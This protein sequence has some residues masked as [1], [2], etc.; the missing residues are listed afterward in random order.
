MKLARLLK[1]V[2]HMLKL[3]ESSSLKKII[4]TFPLTG[5]DDSYLAYNSQ[6]K[7]RL[8]TDA[9]YFPIIWTSI[10]RNGSGYTEKD[11]TRPDRFTRGSQH[12]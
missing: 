5:S 4:T 6:K 1:T 3:K 2:L 11:T 8:S 12:W 9:S 7:R 10:I